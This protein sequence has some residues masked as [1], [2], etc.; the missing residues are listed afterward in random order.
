MSQQQE[1]EEVVVDVYVC[2][3]G[4]RAQPHQVVKVSVE[5]GDIRGREGVQGS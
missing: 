3:S 1:D 4:D 5:K 2:V